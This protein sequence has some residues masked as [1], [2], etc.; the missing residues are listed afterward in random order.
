MVKVRHNSA[1]NMVP[2]RHSSIDG[3]RN[4]ERIPRM[5]SADTKRLA[6]KM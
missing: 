3:K 4:I 2:I 1:E 5:P 6:K